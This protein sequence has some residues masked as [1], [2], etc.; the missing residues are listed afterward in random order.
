MKETIKMTV[1][2]EFEFDLGEIDSDLLNA[3]KEEKGFDLLDENGNMSEESIMME[4]KLY[5]EDVKYDLENMDYKVNNI[6]NYESKI[7]D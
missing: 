3:F 1:D 5:M 4:K 7:V 2:L 6:Y